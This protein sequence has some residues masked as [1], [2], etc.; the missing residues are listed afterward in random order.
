ME[1]LDKN[2]SSITNWVVTKMFLLLLSN[3]GLYNTL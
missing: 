3:N 2:A 1:Q